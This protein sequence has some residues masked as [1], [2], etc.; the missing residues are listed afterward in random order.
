[1][2]EQVWPLVD[3]CH[4]S[5]HVVVVVALAVVL[6]VVLAAPLTRVAKAATHT[7]ARMAKHSIYCIHPMVHI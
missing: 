3:V 5:A 4:V 2:S 1:M 6:A 7:A